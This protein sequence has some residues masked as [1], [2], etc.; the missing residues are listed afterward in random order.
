MAKKVLIVTGDAVEALEVY[1]PYY[2]C[3]EQGYE[4]DIAAPT[5]KKIHTVVHDFEDWETYTEKKGYGLEATKS[6]AEVNPDEYDALIIPG[7][8][9]PEYIRLHPDYGRILRPF[10]E[11]NQPIMVVCHGGISLSPIKDLITGREMTAYIAC[12]PDI[13]ALGATYVDKQTHIDGNLIS[14]HAWNNLPELMREF[15]RQVENS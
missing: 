5:R 3:L 9:A 11:K 2:R 1:Y 7:G 12:K 4:T 15:I 14:G 8:R 6:F 13:E 10:F